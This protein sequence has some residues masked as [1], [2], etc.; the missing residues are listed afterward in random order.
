MIKVNQYPFIRCLNPQR[1]YNKYLDKEIVAPCGK[2]EACLLQKS[3]MHTL[4]CRLESEFCNYC[5]FITLTYDESNIPLFRFIPVDKDETDCPEQLYVAIDVSDDSRYNGRELGRVYAKDLDIW[6]IQN[7]N[8]RGEDI[9]YL[10]Q[11]DV[12]LFLKRLRKRI[13]NEKIRYYCVGEYGPMHLRPH[14]HLLLWFNQEETA[15]NLR[16]YVSEAWRLGFIHV[17]KASAGRA[18]SYVAGYVNSRLDIPPVLN[19]PETKSKCTH[20]TKLGEAFIQDSVEEIHA[21]EYRDFVK[22]SYS[23]YNG[24]TDFSLWR[25]LKTRYFPKCVGFT[26]SDSSELYETYTVVPRLREILGIEK[27]YS[28]AEAMTYLI[29][30]QTESFCFERRNPNL[31]YYIDYIMYKVDHIDYHISMKPDYWSK[32]FQRI[33]RIMYISAYFVDVICEGNPNLYRQKINAIIDFYS[34]EELFNI[35]DQV[36]RANNILNSKYPED[37]KFLY[38]DDLDESD[39]EC[40]LHS[41]AGENFNIACQHNWQNSVKHKKQN[42]TID[43]FNPDNLRY[44][45]IDEDWV[46]FT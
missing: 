24:T 19:L 25:S 29:R 8:C 20:S 40:I 11:I 28:L 43:M 23:F 35:A 32:L 45:D 46:Y 18:A 12:Q 27:P 30:E 2:C 31:Q 42:D 34:K 21:Q 4:K 14:W 10:R 36:Q 37:V 17:G 39:L 22:R 33:Y 3:A 6:S 16:N 7:R 26:I 13:T 44:N 15:Q 9:A 1:I 5:Y 38:L 41:F